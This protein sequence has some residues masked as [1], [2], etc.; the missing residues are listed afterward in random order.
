MPVDR[1]SPLDIG[2]SIG[3]FHP[4]KPVAVTAAALKPLLEAGLR[5][6]SDNMFPAMTASVQGLVPQQ[7]SASAEQFWP[8]PPRPLWLPLRRRRTRRIL[9]IA[10]NRPTIASQQAKGA[11]CGRIQEH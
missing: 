3:T 7:M 9:P 8:P 2:R 1:I 10:R 6:L 4:V 5:E 11:R